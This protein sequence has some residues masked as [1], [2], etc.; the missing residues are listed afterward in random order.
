MPFKYTFLFNVISGNNVNANKRFGG[1]SESYNNSQEMQ[2]GSP[3]V[4]ALISNRLA[5]CSNSVFAVGLRVVDLSQT[6]KAYVYR[7]SAQGTWS[8]DPSGDFPSACIQATGLGTVNS[9]RHR[10]LLRG[11]PDAAANGGIFGIPL[12]QVQQ[13]AQPF[14]DALKN[15]GWYQTQR[16]L[17]STAAKILT[18]SDQGLVTCQ[19]P[20]PFAANQRVRILRTRLALTHTPIQGGVFT[21]ATTPAPSGNTFSIIG[22]PPANTIGGRARFD[23]PIDN[24]YGTMNVE[25]VTL[26]KVGRS[27]FQYVGRR[28][29]A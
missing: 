23:S 29:R 10:L 22:W 1:F 17:S 5:L 8:G 9:Q 14:L 26:R 4:S 3:N 12:V 25:S 16:N 13:R 2:S 15:G 6:S 11:L 27:F 19:G 24:G 18:I 20:Q 21:V 28:K 7:L